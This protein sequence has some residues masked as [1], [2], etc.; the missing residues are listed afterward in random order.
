MPSKIFLNFFLLPSKECIVT[1]SQKCASSAF[2]RWIKRC[3]DEGR[4]CPE[5]MSM[6]THLAK[7][8]HKYKNT[9]KLKSWTIG[10]KP[11]SNKII[12]LYRDPASRIK[13]IFVNKFHFYKNRTIFDGMKKCRNSQKSSLQTYLKILT[14]IEKFR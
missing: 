5:A 7:A 1:W 6:R 12:I 11:A 10:E 3:F 9:N 2:Y 13:S 4:D 14:K 8:G